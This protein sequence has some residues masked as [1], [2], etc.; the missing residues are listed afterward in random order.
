MKVLYEKQLLIHL[1]PKESL[2]HLV[3]LTIYFDAQVIIQ[4]F[5]QILPPLMRGRH[6]RKNCRSTGSVCGNYVSKQH[7]HMI[8]YITDSA[9]DKLMRL[10]DKDTPKYVI[11]K[12]TNNNA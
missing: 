5:S 11:H 7:I 1:H 2:Q 12:T 9:F 6:P 8:Q 10:Y 3:P 4:N